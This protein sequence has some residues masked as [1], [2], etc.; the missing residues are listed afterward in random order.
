M[1]LSKFE[2]KIVNQFLHTVAVTNETEI[3]RQKIFEQIK[4]T[5]A[6][7]LDESVIITTFG[8]GP[9]KTYLPDSDIDITILFRESF[10]KGTKLDPKCKIGSKEFNVVKNILISCSEELDIEDVIFIDAEVKLIKFR[11]QEIPID[12]SFNQ[13]G[14]VCT[15]EYLETVDNILAKDHLF[16]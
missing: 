9:L 2:N 6:Q 11:C 4:Q 3:Q 8:S 5:L 10:L 12:I 15:L 13:I 16:K 14:G 1:S 7:V